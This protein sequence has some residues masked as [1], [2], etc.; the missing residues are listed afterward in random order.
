[1]SENFSDISIRILCC[2]ALLLVTTD[3]SRSPLHASHRGP[4]HDGFTKSADAVPR[5]ASQP[6]L[7]FEQNRG[8]APAGY[9]FV[10][11]TATY[12]AAFSQAG[13]SLGVKDRTSHSGSNVVLRFVGARRPDPVGDAPLDGRVNY[14]RGSSPRAWVVGAPTFGR[15]RYQRL[16]P[17]IDAVFYGTNRQ[18]EYDFVVEP[19]ADPSRIAMRFDGGAVRL[20]GE[21]DLVIAAGATEIVQ[22]RPVA[23]QERDGHRTAVDASYV[24]RRSHVVTLRLGAYDRALPL[25]IDPMIVMSQYLGGSGYEAQ[26]DF[27]GHGGALYLAGQTCS[28]DF[29]TQ[30]ALQPSHTGVNCDGF[31]TK[32]TGDA[33]S[34]VFSTYFGGG[35]QDSI[36]GIAFDAAGAIYVT[37]FTDSGDFPT[38]AG[39]FDR[40]CGSDGTCRGSSPPTGSIASDG[41]VTKLSANGSA[42]VYSTFLG[43]SD[44]EFPADIAV[45]G[46]GEAIVV[47]QTD[48]ADYPTTPGA[49][50]SSKGAINDGFITKVAAD[51]GTLVYSTFFGGNGLSDY[52]FRVALDGAGNTWVVGATESTDMPVLGAFQPTI[53][54]GFESQI[55][56]AFIAKLAPTGSLLF[57][58]YLGGNGNDEAY[59]VALD[60]TGIYI[61][62]LTRST[63]FP[64][65]TTTRNISQKGYAAFVTQLAA[66]GSHVVKTQLLDGNDLDRAAFITITRP[67]SAPILTVLGTSTST[68]LPT[69]PDAIQRASDLSESG[70]LLYATFPLAAS[71]TLAAP[72]YVTY[73]GGAGW[74]FAN[75]VVPDGLDGMF[76][77]T[78][79]DGGFPRINTTTTPR[80][81]TDL[82]IAHLVPPSR[83]TE[84]TP[85]EI[86]LYAA[87]ATT[88]GM[89]WSLVGDPSAANG[90]RAANV[91]RGAPKVTTPAASPGSYV[92]FTFEADAGS[93]RLWIRGIATANSYNNDSVYAQ[94]SDSADASGNAIWRIGTPS[95]TPV[96]LE[97]C[98]SCGVHGW[99]WADNGYGTGVLGQVVRLATTGRHTL[100]FQAREDGLSIDQV[101]LSAA[102]H[103]SAAPGLTKDD[104][105][106]LKKTAAAPP[107]GC[108]D[109]E[110]VLHMTNATPRGT[111]TLTPNS[112]G[113]SGVAMFQKDAG[114]PKILTAQAAPTNYFELT[115]SAD[116][117]TDYRLWM[118]GSATNDFWGNDSVFVQFND[119]VAA[120]NAATWRL[121]TT[122]AAEVNLEDCSGCG[123]KGWGWQ[124]NGWGVGVM[125]PLVRFAGSGTHTIRV[126]TREDGFSIDQIVLSAGRYLN[127][128]PGALKNDATILPA[129]Q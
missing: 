87:D 48:S 123:L 5:T 129:C 62:G 26:A 40:L 24:I 126:Q 74:E 71:G 118:R 47:G 42:I 19:G 125:G 36:A 7:A 2:T 84:S 91:D 34:V 41:F 128:S 49:I 127:A 100:R 15:V 8:Q 10:T 106:V 124:D 79:S 6:P 109:G 43:G 61:V 16:Y 78:S 86:H 11:R 68:D 93:Y 113:A 32:L 81:A 54:N 12:D 33:S 92:E 73:I 60:S 20:N 25:T 66:D 23:Y 69:T 89:D 1:M 102:Q 105:V 29:P 115:F 53:G 95:G 39:A 46:A 96:I 38:T 35:D 99:G 116:A 75:G 85:G 9:A 4:Q 59:D 103:L 80:G 97:D 44:N 64:G 111:W 94:F 77:A 27:V 56:D 63:V 18:L 3:G 101:V 17:G 13:V 108:T 119:S 114:A 50:D 107:D 112:A 110:I 21:G 22:K 82:V 121:G 88:V 90:R 72:S 70:H 58:S 52:M 57:S 83:W 122:S 65:T 14:L 76:V 51:G 117:A 67:A 45:D 31:I 28:T 104:T 120:N 55:R 30:S 98:T 37:G